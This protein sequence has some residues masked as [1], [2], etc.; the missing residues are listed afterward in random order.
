MYSVYMFYATHKPSQYGTSNELKNSNHLGMNVFQNE[1]N[2][3][4]AQSAHK[5]YWGA[6]LTLFDKEYSVSTDPTKDLDTPQYNT[7]KVYI[8]VYI[9]MNIYIHI[10][11]YRYVYIYVCIYMYI[12]VYVYRQRGMNWLWLC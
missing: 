1:S 3:E 11:I 6:K 9:C 4:A 7:K 8:Y 5:L 12:Y 10:Y 2:M